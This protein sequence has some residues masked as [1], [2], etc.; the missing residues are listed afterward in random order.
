MRQAIY[1]ALRTSTDDLVQARLT[2]ILQGKKLDVEA[3]L[4]RLK[5]KTQKK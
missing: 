4:Q 5:K 2:A 1:A 3:F